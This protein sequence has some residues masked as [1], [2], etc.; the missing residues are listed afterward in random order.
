MATKP[1]FFSIQASA[2]VA[3]RERDDSDA[4]LSEAIQTIFPLHTELGFMCW[5]WSYIPLSYKN[6]WSEI[7]DDVVVMATA[8]ADAPHGRLEV[9][10]PSNTFSARW[11]IGWTETI[12]NVDAEWREVGGVSAEWLNG[13]PRL[14]WSRSGFLSE[15]RRP[16]VLLRDALDAAGYRPQLS[17]PMAAM[18]RAI[19][20]CPGPATLYR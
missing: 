4:S 3:T 1:F 15:W 12:V 6:D 7:V 2:P 20:R 14:E 9:E 16:L 13:R 18:D 8:I 5:N 10:W 11:T 17:S 19:E